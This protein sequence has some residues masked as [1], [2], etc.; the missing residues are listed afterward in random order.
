MKITTLKQTISTFLFGPKK[1]KAFRE[2]D[3]EL[4][5]PLNATRVASTAKEALNQQAIH[6]NFTQISKTPANLDT[7]TIHL[8]DESQG[9]LKLLNERINK[10]HLAFINT[11]KN[12]ERSKVDDEK[13]VQ[14][15]ET[16]YL[17]GSKGLSKPYELR[18]KAIL[19]AASL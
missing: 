12:I 13:T 11:T 4:L 16:L 10:I 6:S 3:D 18:K 1:R 14:A 19:D 8:S 7:S 2:I 15:L 9:E 17:E 5:E